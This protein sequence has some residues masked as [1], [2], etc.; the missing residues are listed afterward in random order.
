MPRN[1]I[2]TFPSDFTFCYKQKLKHFI[3]LFY[4]L[5][6][7]KVM[8]N[9]EVDESIKCLIFQIKSLKSVTCACIHQYSECV[10]T[11]FK[12]LQAGHVCSYLLC[13]IAQPQSDWIKSV[14]TDL[15]SSVATDFQFV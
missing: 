15:F 6:K 10:S 13:R 1:G 3:L 14:C 8:H 9:C 7:H 2:N 4:V 11:S 12:Y 5:D